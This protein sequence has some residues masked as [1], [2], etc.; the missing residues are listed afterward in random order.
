MFDGLP[1]YPTPDIWWDV[2]ERNKVTKLWISPAGARVLM[3]YR[4]EYPKEHDLR[5]VKLVAC[6]GEVLNPAAWERLQNKVFDDRL[7]V[8]DHI[9][10]LRPVARLLEI[11]LA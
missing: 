4:D 7:P 10:L 5:S 9:W 8:I 6:A 1:D 2:I 11:R 3:K